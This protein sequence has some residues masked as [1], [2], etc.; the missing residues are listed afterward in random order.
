MPGG[1]LTSRPAD[2]FA[3]TYDASA[4]LVVAGEFTC[5]GSGTQEIV[6][7]GAFGSTD[8]GD[9][10]MRMSLWPDDNTNDN[11]AAPIISN[12]D[13]GII[14]MSSTGTSTVCTYG[15]KPQ[16]TGGV[17]YWIAARSEDNDLNWRRNNA[18][19]NGCNDFP[20]GTWPTDAEWDGASDRNWY[21]GF[22]AVYEAAVVDLN[23]NVSECLPINEA[24]HN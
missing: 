11:P 2:D 17:D 6:E 13:S 12:S 8:T 22:W 20:S 16:L 23:I 14:V 18:G 1:F 15:T 3:T 4:G 24:L 5:G 19:G 9:A 10:N 21:V 7:I